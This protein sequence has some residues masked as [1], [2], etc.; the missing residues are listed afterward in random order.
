MLLNKIAD[1]FMGVTKLG[2]R[3]LQRNPT[4]EK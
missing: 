1:I 3:N 2:T 4:G